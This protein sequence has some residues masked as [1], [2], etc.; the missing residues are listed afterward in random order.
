MANPIGEDM[1]GPYACV[2]C[3]GTFDEPTESN[4]E[5]DDRELTPCCSTTLFEQV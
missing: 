5:Q 3:G 1:G 4:L 2:E